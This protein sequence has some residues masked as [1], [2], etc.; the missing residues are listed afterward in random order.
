MQ[1][2]AK[3]GEN[4]VHVGTVC[5]EGLHCWDH[6]PGRGNRKGVVEKAIDYLTQSWWRTARVAA[7]AEAQA[8]LDRWCVTVADH[9][10]RP[11]PAA[12][13]DRV[14]CVPAGAD[15]H[16]PGGIGVPAIQPSGTIPK[17]HAG[18]SSVDGSGP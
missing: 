16:S 4:A 5:Q 2:A 17:I 10:V 8:D 13:P 1:S 3:L 14:R 18:A 9:R 6:A 15:I 12:D 11:I 7:A